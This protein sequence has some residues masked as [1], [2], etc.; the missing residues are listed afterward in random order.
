MLLRWIENTRKKPRAVRNQYAFLGAVIMT[1][2]IASIWGVSLSVRFDVNP[3]SEEETKESTGAF[4]RFLGETKQN[5]AA[6][7][8]ARKAEITA[9]TTEDVAAT[10]SEPV[11]P[12]VI[13][14]LEKE[15]LDYLRDEY[16]ESL[17]PEPRKV[18]IATTSA[19][20]TNA[21][22]TAE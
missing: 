13:P 17:L 1:V 14:T 12:I 11:S 7:M 18:L 16:E 9:E 15:N 22:D 5:I 21:T 20:H 8:A 2:C 19:E 6:T 10:S 4:A 3:E